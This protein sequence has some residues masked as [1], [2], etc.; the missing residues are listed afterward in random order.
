MGLARLSVFEV[1]YVP[2]ALTSS[3]ER[4]RAA[5]WEMTERSDGRLDG[6]TGI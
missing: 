1:V 5:L 3:L 6:G 2:I 4:S